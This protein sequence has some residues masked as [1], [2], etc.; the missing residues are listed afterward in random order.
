MH[1]HRFVFSVLTIISVASTIQSAEIDPY[2]PNDTEVI[3]SF[4]AER[5]LSTPIGMRYI[6]GAMDQALKDHDKL[7]GILK[8]AGFDPKRDLQRITIGMSASEPNRSFVIVRGRFQVAR[9]VEAAATIAADSRDILKI[10]KIGDRAIYEV[11]GEKDST[12]LAFVSETVLLATLQRPLLVASLEKPGEKFGKVS[13][14]LTQLAA[15]VDGK[16]AAW[17]AALPGPLKRELP[18]PMDD[19]KQKQAFDNLVGATGTVR[20]DQDVRI[21]LTLQ[22]SDAAGAQQLAVATEGVL[23]LLVFLAPGIVKEKPELGP[24]QDVLNSARSY[25][26]GANVHVTIDITAKT[27]EKMI[28]SVKQ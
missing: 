21:H 18:L 2:L 12:Y 28:Q 6:K 7:S 11:P 16:Q 15:A 24:L 17:L 25:A 27:I 13:P 3:V 9:I 23:K 10:H 1:S 20:M 14:A 5:A 4:N 22:S 26:K 8:D 19:P